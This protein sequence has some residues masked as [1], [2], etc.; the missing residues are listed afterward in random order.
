MQKLLNFF[1][2]ILTFAFL[3]LIV[4]FLF[5][6][7]KFDIVKKDE[8]E[9]FVSHKMFLFIATALFAVCVLISVW[10]GV[11]MMTDFKLKGIV[12]ICIQII[13][14]FALVYMYKILI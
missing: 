13:F 7:I 4:Y 14:L 11:L 9:L 8:I 10:A 1:G 5:C 3:V 6:Y 2:T 12:I